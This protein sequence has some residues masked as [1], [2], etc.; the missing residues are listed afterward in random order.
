MK[1]GVAPPPPSVAEVFGEQTDN[2]VAYAHRLAT[3]GVERGLIG[4][5]EVDR[6]WERHLLNSAVVAELLGPTERVV[7]VGSGAGLPGIPLALA[8][9]DLRMTLV[10]PMQR[11]VAFLAEVVEALTLNV[12]IVRGR[13]EDRA[14]VQRAGEADAVVSRA[15]AP[16]DR[17]GRWCA[18]LLRDGGRMIALKG[19]RAAAEVAAHG[20]ALHALGLH[21]VR[22]VRCGVDVLEPAATV[23]VAHRA[24]GRMPA[25]AKRRTAGG[26]Q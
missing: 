6:L 9:P 22:V 12:E 23:V 5:R 25:A 7:D 20:A 15:V 21:D 24:R 16:L 19:E 1:H 2:A 18:P 13:A 14:V 26:R 10:E 3:D 8:R 17:L 11:R 4:P